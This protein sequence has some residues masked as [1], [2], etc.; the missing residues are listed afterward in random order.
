MVSSFL[1]LA[2]ILSKLDTWKPVVHMEKS[3]AKVS[4]QVPG[5]H[6]QGKLKLPHD[7]DYCVFSK[8]CDPF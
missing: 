6:G 7:I 4:G 2:F 1:Q 5:M 3:L 8:V